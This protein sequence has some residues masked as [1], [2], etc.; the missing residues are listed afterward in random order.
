M[1]ACGGRHSFS[2]TTKLDGEKDLVGVVLDACG[3]FLDC[4]VRTGERMYLSPEVT[5]YG[6][7]NG[8]LGDKWFVICCY[9]SGSDMSR[10]K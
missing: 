4:Q 2:S 8:V 5:I 10:N 9:V 6:V 7:F 3:L 1:D